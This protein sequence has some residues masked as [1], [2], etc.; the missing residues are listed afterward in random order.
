ML[1]GGKPGLLSTMWESSTLRLHQLGE[2]TLTITHDSSSAAQNWYLETVSLESSNANRA[3]YQFSSLMLM[4]RKQ[5][6]K[7][8]VLLKFCY[9][10]LETTHRRILNGINRLKRVLKPPTLIKRLPSLGNHLK[11]IKLKSGRAGGNALQE[12]GWVLAPAV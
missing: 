12:G 6:L 5:N 10:L 4:E 8:P 7:H 1:R 11:D 2:D 3:Q 9:F